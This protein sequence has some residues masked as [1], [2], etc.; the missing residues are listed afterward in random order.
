MNILQLLRMIIERDRL[1][2]DLFL[3]LSLIGA[4]LSQLGLARGGSDT[5]RTDRGVDRGG[6]GVDRAL[7]AVRV[8]V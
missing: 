6:R 8:A 3:H 1:L 4:D 5:D 2:I 7:T